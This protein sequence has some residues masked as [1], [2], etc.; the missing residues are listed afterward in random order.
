M[1]ISVGDLANAYFSLGATKRL[2]RCLNKASRLTDRLDGCSHPDVAEDMINL[3][4]I[5]EQSGEYG[6]AEKLN[7]AATNIIEKW[8]GPNDPEAAVKVILAPT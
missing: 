4:A 6:R 3:G 8:Y 1:A 5:E 2:K 7:R